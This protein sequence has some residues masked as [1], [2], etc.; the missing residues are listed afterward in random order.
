MDRRQG[1]TIVAVGVALAAAATAG[2]GIIVQEK[3]VSLLTNTLVMHAGRPFVPLSELARALGGSGRYDP[4][5]LRY[6]IRPGAAGLLQFN[7]GGL[8][9][10]GIRRLDGQVPGP[11]FSLRIGGQDVAIEDQDHVLLPSGDP[12]VSLSFLARLLGGLARFDPSR[13]AWVL[14]PGGAANPLRFR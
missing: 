14:P 8:G 6:E 12:A 9:A 7:P 13:G 2:A 1:R 3:P 11:S 10:L 4:V 5:R